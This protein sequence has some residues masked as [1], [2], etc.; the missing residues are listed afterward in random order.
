VPLSALRRSLRLD[1]AAARVGAE[2]SNMDELAVGADGSAAVMDA[3]KPNSWVLLKL[4]RI[5]A[6]PA[7]AAAASPAFVPLGRSAAAAAAVAA[8][9]AATAAAEAEA[10]ARPRLDAIAAEELRRIGD[11]L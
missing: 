1:S 7:P 6:R 4:R 11:V 9:A 8:V 5:G 3:L 2:V 10:A